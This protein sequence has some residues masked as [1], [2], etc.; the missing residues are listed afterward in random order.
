MLRFLLSFVFVLIFCA[1]SHAQGDKRGA[2]EKNIDRALVFLKNHQE[3]ADGSWLSN[4]TPH[5]GVTALAV[6]AFLSAGHVPDEGPYGAVV[7]K[8]IRYILAQQKADGIFN[9]ASG[10]TMYQQ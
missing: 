3:K 1:S 4:G 9:C 8:G 10:A 2:L 7:T 5:S 6:M